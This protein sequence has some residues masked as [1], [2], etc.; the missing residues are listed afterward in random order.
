M[1]NAK[2]SDFV[3][4]HVHTEYSLLDGAS[5]I[6]DLV[7]LAKKNGMNAVAITDHGAMYGVIDFYK[8][9]KQAGIKPLI[10]CEVYVAK[11]G[12]TD[13]TPKVDD[14]PYHLV[15]IAEDQEGYKNLL[16]LVSLAYI[17]G[18]YYKPRIDLELLSS[19]SRG[20]IGLSGCLAGQIPSLILAGD[21][22][23]AA[24]IAGTLGD[25][26]GRERFFLELQDHGLPEQG[27]V[28]RALVK[29]SG[30]LGLGIVA[31]NDSHYNERRDA[32]AHDILLCIQTGKTVRDESRLRFPNDEFYFKSGREMEAI[33]RDLPQA[34]TNT[35]VIAD[36]CNVE[37][38]FGSI[39]LPDYDLP[40]GYDADSFLRELCHERFRRRFP[41]GDE[42]ALARLEYELGVIEKMGYAGYFLI[43]WDFIEYSK[44]KGIPVGP[45]RGSAA[46]SLVAYVLGITDVHPL[47]YGLL[48]ER[49]LNP[50]RVTMPDMDIDFCFERRQEVIDYVVRKYGQQCVAQII[51]FGTMA[52]RAAIRDVGRTLSMPYSQ[53]DRI[54][55]MVP[56]QHGMTLDR[57][58]EVAPDL[59]QICEADSQVRR[60]I[61]LAKS[62]EG[63]PRHASVH[64][65]GVVISGKPLW[66]YVPLQKMSDGTVVTQF[67]MEGLEDLGLLK[68]DFLGLRTLTVLHDTVSLISRTQ[69]TELRL[70]EIPFDDTNTYR[71]LGEGETL[72]VFQLESGWVRETL[73]ELKPSRF[74][75]L[76]ALV[77]LCRPGPMENIPAFIENK[78]GSPRYPHPI[79]EPILRETYGII[80]YQEQVMQAVSA[81]AGFSLGQA[82]ILRR[83]MGKKKPELIAAMKEDF[84]KGAKLK[85]IDEETAEEIF[86]L[87]DRFAGYGFNKSHAAAYALIAYRASYLKANYPKEYM[88]ALLTSVASSTDKIG[89]YV[90]ECRRMNI[91]V[92]PPDINE[93]YEKFTV[94]QAGIR[95]GLAGVKNVGHG[96]IASIVEARKAGAFRSLRDVCERVDTRLLNKRALESLVKAGAFDSLGARRSQLLAALDDILEHTQQS[97]RRRRDLKGQTS[98]FELVD[99]ADFGA[100][101][102]PLPD[103]PEFPREKLLGMEKEVL[104]LYVS[105]HPLRNYSAELSRKVTVRLGNIDEVEDGRSV[106]IGGL[107]N[108]AKVIVTRSGERMLFAQVE[109]LTGSIEVT[110]FPRVYERF[111]QYLK[112]DALVFVRGRV[113]QQEERVKVIAEEVSPIVGTGSVFIRIEKETGKAW[114]LEELKGV[115]TNYPGNSPVY[116]FFADIGKVVSTNSRY[117]VGVSEQLVEEVEGLLGKGSVILQQN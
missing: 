3:H 29:M 43:V 64:A 20:L 79:L 117:W 15:L 42:E 18:F 96:A 24:D 16:K 23:G 77:A 8:K 103:I 36:R 53:V 58:L 65:A 78:R 44:K 19:H 109:D 83:G 115:L 102:D 67:T 116:L 105:G 27:V 48:F 10:G 106:V 55:K 14:E 6:D 17:E 91:E 5:R 28:N 26:L 70:D 93:S 100:A 110:V 33:F 98:F 4:L 51:T 87:I 62:V 66:E 94:A 82:D 46:G 49:F 35:R 81:I 2:R 22:K 107:I 114:V 21:L 88:A 71:L 47:K 104:G 57:A 72:G 90:E 101:A 68:M 99:G 12:R 39:H 61:E 25:I 41:D 60:L 54:A 95:F 52:A 34:I 74:E 92:L 111:A 97:R 108:S 112:P 50:E 32:E 38:E 84:M 76:I 73:R 69:G 13:R 113:S 45:G 7:S 85:G 11:R 40:E 75:D 31:T 63:L 9:C 56:F 86:Q 1:E 80:V 89:L 59:R 37:L 30:E